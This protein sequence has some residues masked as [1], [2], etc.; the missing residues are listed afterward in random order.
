MLI[1]AVLHKFFKVPKAVVQDRIP[2]PMHRDLVAENAPLHR[3][4]GLL[5]PGGKSALRRRVNFPP[6]PLASGPAVHVR[7]SR[8]SGETA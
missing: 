6:D 3:V 2:F 1:Y 7:T 4:L 5:P 8:N